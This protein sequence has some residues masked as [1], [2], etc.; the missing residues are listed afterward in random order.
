LSSFSRRRRLK[1]VVSCKCR[2][3]NLRSNTK[4]SDRMMSRSNTNLP[5]QVYFK[6][7]DIAIAFGLSFLSLSL[8]LLNRNSSFEELAALP[9]NYFLFAATPF[10]V[11]FSL[12]HPLI[13]TPIFIVLFV[14]ALL[15]QKRI[16][17]IILM[18]LLLLAWE[19]YGIICAIQAIKIP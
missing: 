2:R 8:L 1:L 4:K 10:L 17:K 13:A 6:A 14:F 9:L 3:E 18:A 15:L 5:Y 11:V 12:W 7:V 16:L 19:G